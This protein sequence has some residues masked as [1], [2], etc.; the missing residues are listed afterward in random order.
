[1]V[2]IDALLIVAMM[3]FVFLPITDRKTARMK[4]CMVC[5][6]AALLAVSIARVPTS[7][8]QFAS[9]AHDR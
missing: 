5:A 8:L 1:M 2:V 9:A 6:I 7:D 3:F 4:L